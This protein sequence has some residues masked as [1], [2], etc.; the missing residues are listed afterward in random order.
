[1]IYRYQIR[2]GPLGTAD[3]GGW[4]AQVPALPGCMSD[5]ETPQEALDNVMDAIECWLETA[6]AD[7]RPIPAPVVEAA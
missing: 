6:R 4:Y 7:G 1:M 3:G 5:G 2:L